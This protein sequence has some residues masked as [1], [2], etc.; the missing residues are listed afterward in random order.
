MCHFLASLHTPSNTQPP[1]Q[2]VIMNKTTNP[3]WWT[4]TH[5][6]AWERT[7]A[8]F[9]RDWDQTVHDVGGRKPDT[10]QDVDDTLKQAAGKQPIPPRGERTYEERQP[11]Y[12]FGFG[13]HTQ[14]ADKYPDWNDELEARLKRDWQETYPARRDQWQL[15][16]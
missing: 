13:A 9:K 3:S 15:D 8:A 6:S 1:E 11:A 14:Y 7:K 10:N 16:R 2:T 5:D 12:R 4:A